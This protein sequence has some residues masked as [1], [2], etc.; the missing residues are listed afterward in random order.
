MQVQRLEF[1]K[2]ELMRLLLAAHHQSSVLFVLS[3]IALVLT[4]VGTNLVVSEPNFSLG[5][6]FIA[7]AMG[8]ELAGYWICRNT[9]QKIDDLMSRGP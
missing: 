3:L 1:E 5:L 7:S 4:G 9:G 2:E 8:V 6:I